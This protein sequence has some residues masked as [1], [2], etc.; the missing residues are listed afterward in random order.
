VSRAEA[1]V[2]GDSVAVCSR[3]Q[4]LWAGFGIGRK[5]AAR[6]NT[7]SEEIDRELA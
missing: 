3:Q 5:T 6:R 2:E 1:S 7:V 4:K